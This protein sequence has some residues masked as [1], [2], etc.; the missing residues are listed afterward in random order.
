MLCLNCDGIKNQPVGG[1]I[2]QPMRENTPEAK[3]QCQCFTAVQ[4]G[5]CNENCDRPT[6]PPEP[7]IVRQ[8][9]MTR[10][11]YTPYCGTMK[12]ARDIGGCDNPRTHFTG[13]Q[14]RCPKCGF[15]TQF[16]EEFITRYKAK[17]K[18]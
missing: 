1:E 2:K 8:N 10:P 17:W 4:I 9:L 7:T 14:F 3:I 6:D 11:G 12:A 16:E 5:T 13:T 18:L 15:E